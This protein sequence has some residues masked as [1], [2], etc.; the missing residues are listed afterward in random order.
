MSDLRK[1]YAARG[2]DLLREAMG[3]HLWRQ[4]ECV[5]L[6]PSE[7]TPSPAVRALGMSD[8]AF[9]YAEHRNVKGMGEVFYYQGTKF[10]ARTEELLAA[11]MCKYLGCANVETRVTSGTMSNAVMFSAL[12]D[13]KNRDVKGV[14]PKRLGYVM[15]NLLVA[16]GHLSAQPMGALHDYIAKD[17][18]TG[19]NAVVNF[20][21]CEDN[22]YRMDVEKA[23]VLLDQYKPEL[24]VFGKSM[25]LHKEP[26]AALRKFVDEQGIKT[27]IMYDMAHVLGIAGPSFQDPFAEGV[28]VVTGST[29]KTFFG[30]QRGIVATNWT[31]DSEKYGLWEAV[32]RRTFPGSVSNHHLGSLLGQL[33]AAYEMNACREAYQSAVVHNA[34]FFA[35]ALVEAG[36]NVEGDAAIDYTETHQVILN[37]GDGN[38]PAM[39]E[40]LEQSNIIVNHQ[41][42]PR[43]KS[44]N[45]ASGLR[46]GVS[47]MTRFGF[48]DEAFTRLA[49]LMAECILRG[50]NVREEIIKLRAQYTTPCYCFTDAELE[51]ALGGLIAKLGL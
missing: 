45:T 48:G 32:Q 1:E 15:N 27:T 51:G 10:I 2:A 8:P 39:A 4:N 16:G 17:P 21:V 37:V 25:V 23:K 42:L 20:P 26:V 36:L 18:A 31:E 34:K 46:L 49:E 50:K 9:R 41:A 14:D 5:N 19:K 11:E 7:M 13:Y 33:M 22:P 47:E 40:Q 6:I 3:N 30:A 44:F 29:H 35:K 12:M 28:E 24:M 38:G 43:E